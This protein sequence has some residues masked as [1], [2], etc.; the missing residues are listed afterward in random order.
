M[1]LHFYVIQYLKTLIRFCCFGANV[2]CVSLIILIF[3]FAAF[4][5]KTR[6]AVSRF[7]YSFATF[8][9]K[10]SGWTQIRILFRIRIRIRKQV[11]NL[12][13]N[14]KQGQFELEELHKWFYWQFVI[15]VVL[16]RRTVTNSLRQLIITQ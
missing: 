10:L 4:V 7:G 2:N 5:I 6:V 11:Q 1:F 15:F 3:R 8:C 14:L 13:T 9:I 16:T 12:R